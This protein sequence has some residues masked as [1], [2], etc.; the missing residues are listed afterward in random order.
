MTGF[1]PCGLVELP[2]P[3]LDIVL[4]KGDLSLVGLKLP[5]MEIQEVQSTLYMKEQVTMASESVQRIAHSVA[6]C[7]GGRH[8]RK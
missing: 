8:G 2:D 5:E 1:S 4:G 3:L 6:V 7:N